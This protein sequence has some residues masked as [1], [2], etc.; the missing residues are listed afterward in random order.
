MSRWLDDVG[1]PQYKDAFLE[2][3]SASRLDWERHDLVMQG[4]REGAQLPHSGGSAAAKSILSA[5][6][7]LYKAWNTGPQFFL[8]SIVLQSSC[9][10][11]TNHSHLELPLNV[12]GVI[13]LCHSFHPGAAGPQLP[14][15]GA[16]A[17]RGTRGEE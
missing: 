11:C 9:S 10:S 13:P 16:E 6:S 15:R 5:T 17:A 2:A 1:L 8:S 4:G 7:P 3:R 14:A 12:T